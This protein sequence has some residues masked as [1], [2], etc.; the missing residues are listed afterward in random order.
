[1]KTLQEIGADFQRL[2][3][4][5]NSDAARTAAIAQLKAGNP[6]GLEYCKRHCERLAEFGRG[7]GRTVARQMLADIAA[8]EASARFRQEI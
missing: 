7:I 8:I 3:N 2:T 6:A 1:M 4:I 5:E